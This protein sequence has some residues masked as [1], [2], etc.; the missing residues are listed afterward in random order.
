MGEWDFE[1]CEL[2]CRRAAETFGTRCTGAAWE[3]STAQ[4]FMLWSAAFRGDL[5]GIVRRVPEFLAE[6]RARGDRHAETALI[7]SPLHLMRLAAD[8]PEQL[9]AQCAASM[10][11][12]PSELACFQHMCGAYVLAQTDLYQARVESAWDNVRYAWRMLRSAHLARVQFQRIDLLGLRGRAAL[13]RAAATAGR[14]R[15]RWLRAARQDAVRLRREDVP[16]ALA[17]G[18]LICGG[19][20]HLSGNPEES[21]A[22]FDS[23]GD[24]FAA[25]S[26]Q[27][28]AAVSRV[29]RDS[30]SGGAEASMQSWRRLEELGVANTAAWLRL[31]APGVA[32]PHHVSR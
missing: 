1:K 16:A 30:V 15:W 19:V 31:W 32:A 29:A 12:W 21:R 18:A 27:L 5:R 2:L 6:A 11:E 3:T 9:R 13:A 22:S 20:A 26:M 14:H 4:A 28:H 17:F 8:E 25:L 7:L 23:A 10:S 24:L